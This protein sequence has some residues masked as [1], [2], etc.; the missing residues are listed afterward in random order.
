MCYA[1]KDKKENK[2]PPLTFSVTNAIL[3]RRNAFSTKHPSQP[4]PALQADSGAGNGPPAAAELGQRSRR[5]RR[6]RRGA[7]GAV[8]RGGPSAGVSPGVQR[9]SEL[10][11][12]LRLW[13]AVRSAAPFFCYHNC[14]RKP[15]SL[16]K[17]KKKN[18]K[19]SVKIYSRLCRFGSTFL[20]FPST[21]NV[22]VL[23][24]KTA[25][26]KE[27]R[28]RRSIATKSLTLSEAHY[29]FSQRHQINSNPPAPN[30]LFKAC[31][32]I[33]SAPA[34]VLS[35]NLQAEQSR[36]LSCCVCLQMSG[37]P[38]QSVAAHKHY[39]CYQRYSLRSLPR[40]CLW[41]WLL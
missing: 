26:G 18:Q 36:G 11:L 7:G 34:N 41:K 39:R 30:K 25:M 6:C 8:R 35:F 19:V 4:V 9:R 2:S 23:I 28:G 27:N 32:I 20:Y 21:L 33:P 24:S 29:I 38:P 37:T 12:Q 14:F 10:S 3:R 40:Y 13:P 17:E 31:R 5:G 15:G 1:A 16:Q 22:L